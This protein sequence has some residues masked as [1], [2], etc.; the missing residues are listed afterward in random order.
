L[1]LPHADAIKRDMGGKHV[2][3]LSD[4]EKRS[5]AKKSTRENSPLPG[6]PTS[7]MIVV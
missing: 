1:K 7:A 6:A 2:S 5:R 3:A 4:A